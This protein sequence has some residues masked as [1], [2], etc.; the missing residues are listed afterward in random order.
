MLFPLISVSFSFS[1]SFFFFCFFG[2]GI[3]I[4]WILDFLDFSLSP[5]ILKFSDFSYL[6][7]FL[8]PSVSV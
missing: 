2:N 1:F 5:F 6:S 3:F 4:S 8:S 7:H